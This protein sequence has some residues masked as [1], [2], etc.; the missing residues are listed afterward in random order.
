MFDPWTATKEE[1]ADDIRDF[2]TSEAARF[3]VLQWD[4][5]QEMQQMRGRV[6]AGDG[7][8]LMECVSLV[9][10]YRLAPAGW[11]AECFGNTRHSVRTGDYMSWDDVFGKPHGNM[12]DRKRLDC[13]N[14]NIMRCNAIGNYL[15]GDLQRHPD[16]T[17]TRRYEE[18]A[19]LFPVTPER[20]ARFWRE[21]QE[22]RQW[23]ADTVRQRYERLG[24]AWPI[25][26]PE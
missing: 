26:D 9:F 6:E 15:T 4:A 5:A 3:R 8:A 11:L 20:A 14:E 12:T 17:M 21:Y 7:I 10:Q 16:K 24:V 2:C 18:V 1:M 25:Y 22:D 13:D 23:L 19:D